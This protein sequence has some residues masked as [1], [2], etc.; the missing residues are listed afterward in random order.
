MADRL[1]ETKKAA[2]AE[3]KPERLKTSFLVSSPRAA[4]CPNFA[5]TVSDALSCDGRIRL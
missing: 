2:E 3:K 4:G 1:L 5:F